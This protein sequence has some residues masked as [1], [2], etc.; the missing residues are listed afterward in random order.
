VGA[1]GGEVEPF[2]ARGP[3]PESRC[4]RS[5][6]SGDCAPATDVAAYGAYAHGPSAREAFGSEP[7]AIDPQSAHRVSINDR[8]A[9]QSAATDLRQSG[10][11]AVSPDPLTAQ[12]P[13]GF[14]ALRRYAAGR[15]PREGIAIFPIRKFGNH[16]PLALF[17]F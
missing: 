12:Q 2:A 8:R 13:T 5:V 17:D 6:G 3:D 7:V 10:I 9:G 14:S 11:G 16:N 15:A 4:L 1:I